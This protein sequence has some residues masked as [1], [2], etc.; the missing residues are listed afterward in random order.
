MSET[1]FQGRLEEV[2]GGSWIPCLNRALCFQGIEIQRISF[3]FPL[4]I[5]LRAEGKQERF[6][7]LSMMFV[8]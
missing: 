8:V 6:L 4:I 2:S 1:I 7:F 5:S 3:D